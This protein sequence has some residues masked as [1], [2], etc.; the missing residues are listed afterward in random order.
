MTTLTRFNPFLL[1]SDFTSAAD[2]GLARIFQ[3]PLRKLSDDGEV[4]TIWYRAPEC[5][6]GC[7]HYTRAI[8]VFA[9]GCIFYELMVCAALFPG[10][11]VTREA[12]AAGGGGA[13]GGRPFQEHQCREVFR[14]L[15]KPSVEAWPGLVDCPHYGAIK[16]WPARD[17]T[18]RLMERIPAGAA[19]GSA[20]ARDLL[21]RML[22]YDPAKRIT[23][24]EALAHPYFREEPRPDPSALVDSQGARISYPARQ[25]KPLSTSKRM[26]EHESAPHVQAQ[27]QAAATASAAA[28]AVAAAAAASAGASSAHSSTYAAGGGRSSAPP[29]ASSNSANTSLPPLSLSAAQRQRLAGMGSQQQ[30]QQQPLVAPQYDASQFQQPP[31]KQHRR[32]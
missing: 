32:A 28:S 29:P 8:D 2:F 12:G 10:K 3:S 13:A 21:E 5:L 30:Q 17:Y 25:A 31:A 11:E 14:T 22:I 19:N 1:R 23:A 26:R 7:K 6:L 4:V 20:A 24:E 9:V 27:T 16:G 15:G 18:Y